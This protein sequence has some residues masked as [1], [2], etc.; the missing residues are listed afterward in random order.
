MVNEDAASRLK[1]LAF[2]LKFGHDLFSAPD[3]E[4][5]AAMAASD[6]RTILAFR[7]SALFEIREK[8]ELILL[9]QFAQSVCNP[10]SSAALDFK[11]L[12]AG[13]NFDG[14]DSCII[15]GKRDGSYCL[16]CKLSSPARYGAEF[17]WLLEYEHEIPENIVNA[18]KLLGRSIAEALA[19]AGLSANSSWKRRKKIKKFWKYA[20][21]FAI[22]LAAMFIPVPESTTAEFILQP[23]QT[24][25]AYAWFDG[26]ISKCFKQEGDIV[27][28]GEVVA[29]YDTAQ[30][31]YKLAN[32]RST[33]QEIEAELALEQQNAF[34]DESK[35]GKAKLLQAKCDSMRIAV[36]EAQWY[37]KHA[38]IVAPA[39]GILTL[40]T[41]RAEQLTGKAVRTG[42]K[43]FDVL[44]TKRAV[45]EI[46][47]PEQ[48]SS[49]LQQEFTI[50][51]YLYTRPEESITAR[52]I[53]IAP[54]SELTERQTY[55]YPVLA[56]LPE[57]Q[58][59]PE[60]RFG[61]RGTAKLSGK[62]VFAGYYLFK[63]LILYFRKW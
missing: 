10:H 37:L 38:D 39:D 47:I 23:E 7:N 59:L 52:V 61:M 27:R 44:S 46:Q 22:L 31:E 58:A 51:L 13:A 20:A 48:E 53:E 9:G 45:A 8:R 57:N 54:H 34:T 28:K 3:I 17:I 4:A 29:R 41:G 56:K 1:T 11:E 32:A 55:C 18:A 60:L 33:L 63:S 43:L 30:L 16:C 14:Q 25:A 40:A 50:K 26:P 6:S 42:D 15:R 19:F 62:R 5:V 35:L 36:Q 49:I 12:A 2:M 21:I 24:T